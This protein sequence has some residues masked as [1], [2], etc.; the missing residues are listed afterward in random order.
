M[1]SMYVM[2]YQN[3]TYVQGSISSFDVSE[4]YLPNGWAHPAILGSF[5]CLVI[6]V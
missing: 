3:T 5:G 1:N 4:S 2:N 6:Y